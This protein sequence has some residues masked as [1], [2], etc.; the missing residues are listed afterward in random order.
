[1]GIATSYKG[2]IALSFVHRQCMY[3]CASLIPNDYSGKKVFTHGKSVYVEVYIILSHV[4][5][6]R[7]VIRTNSATFRAELDLHVVEVV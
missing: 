2:A 3:T 7:T 5:I 1:M 6:S 4:F